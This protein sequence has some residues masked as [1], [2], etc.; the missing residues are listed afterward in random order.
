MKSFTPENFESFSSMCEAANVVPVVHTL[1]ADL[2]TPLGAY[3]KISADATHSF[4][5]ESVEGGVNL[6]RYSFLGANPSMIADGDAHRTN[7]SKNGATETQGVPFF[8]FLREHFAKNNLFFDRENPVFTGGAI[9]YFGF[10]AVEWF[11]PTLAQDAP[12][13]KNLLPDALWMFYRTIVAFDHA[14]QL[15][16]IITLVFT[17]EADGNAEK[18]EKL[19]QDAIAHNG[20]LIETLEQENF[21]FNFKTQNKV[22]DATVSSNWEKEAF[23]NAVREIKELIAAGECYQVVL[24]QCFSRQ[25]TA[26]PVSIY[27]ALRSLN[28]SPYMFLL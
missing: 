13:K 22:S 14:R 6:A 24:S 2:L 9:G 27:R 20:N 26:S 25:T 4:L 16:K 23:E 18:L 5:L 19:Y 12:T 28:P 21:S 15:I 11:E 17:E 1:P 7:V 8:Q 10:S 3:L